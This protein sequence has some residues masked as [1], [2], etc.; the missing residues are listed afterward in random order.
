MRL[1]S[2]LAG[3]EH[4]NYAIYLRVC[5]DVL[6]EVATELHTQTHFK[7]E[8]CVEVKYLTRLEQQVDTI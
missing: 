7:C 2:L 8:E 1:S 3:T 4:A 6:N 5:C